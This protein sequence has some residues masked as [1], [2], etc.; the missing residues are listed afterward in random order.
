MG[1]VFIM[2]KTLILPLLAILVFGGPIS[3]LSVSAADDSDFGLTVSDSLIIYI[4]KMASKEFSIKN[5]G[6]N[7]LQISR[8]T[9]PMS[10]PVRNFK[11]ITEGGLEWMESN[12]AHTLQATFAE[13][14][15]ANAITVE[16]SQCQLDGAPGGGFASYRGKDALLIV[17]GLVR[18]MGTGAFNLFLRTKITHGVSSPYGAIQ[19]AESLGVFTYFQDGRNKGHCGGTGGLALK[20]E[21]KDQFEKKTPLVFMSG[22]AVNCYFG[23]QHNDFLLRVRH[24]VHFGS[25]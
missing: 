15:A 21:E 9:I 17:D 19:S 3:L 24:D 2:M 4:S 1:L 23:P 10:T 12:W 13:D 11:K 7:T 16:G 18:A 5:E 8:I 20:T 25:K 6:R 14:T 22:G